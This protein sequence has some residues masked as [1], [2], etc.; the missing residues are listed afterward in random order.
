MKACARSAPCRW[1]NETKSKVPF[2]NRNGRP[3]N[4]DGADSQAAKLKK[5]LPLAQRDIANLKNQLHQAKENMAKERAERSS[6]S[7][8]EDSPED[9]VGSKRVCQ[10]AKR[11][12]ASRP[13]PSSPSPPQRGFKMLP[14][15]DYSDSEQAGG[16]PGPTGGGLEKE[17][18]RRIRADDAYP[19][20]WQSTHL[21]DDGGETPRASGH[22][23]CDLHMHMYR[24]DRA[25]VV[26]TLFRSIRFQSYAVES[27]IQTANKRIGNISFRIQ[28]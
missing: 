18:R 1:P 23:M 2:G 27:Q 25:E 16:G 3:N 5:D 22:C 4:S 21:S 20:Y 7:K 6:K 12:K 24:Y 15:G 14:T 13:G 19:E 28:L 10:Q 9:E 26:S 17:D 11:A 8:K